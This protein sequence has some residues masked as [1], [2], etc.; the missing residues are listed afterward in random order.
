MAVTVLFLWRHLSFL[1]RT[2]GTFYHDAL[3][4]SSHD[5][6]H[7]VLAAKRIALEGRVARMV[8][9]LMVSLMPQF[10]NIAIVARQRCRRQR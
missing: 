6:R 7:A 3:A 10:Y 9:H 1:A 5:R 2:L 4:I 8:V